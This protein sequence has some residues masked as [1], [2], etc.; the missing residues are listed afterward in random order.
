MSI[1]Y[2]LSVNKLTTPPSYAPRVRPRATTGL[3]ALAQRI[4]DA[5]T[6][7]PA[8]VQ[9]TLVAFTELIESE[10]IAGNWVQL[11]GIGIITT[12]LTGR[13][14]GPTDPLPEDSK[15][16][17]GFRADNRLRKNL[18]ANAQFTRID[19]SDQAPL[20][21]A[22]SVKVGIILPDIRTNDVLELLG[23]RLSV[24]ESKPDEG[25][26]LVP[27]T[28]PALRATNYL[29]NGDKKLLFAVPGG[30]TDN[31]EYTLQVRN[32]RQNSVALRTTSWP[33]LLAGAV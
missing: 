11:D 18:R 13:L 29:S 7:A 3:E 9:A 25:A 5:S 26:F 12:S 30:I 24:D 33:T 4:A 2:E 10:L 19:P 27:A 17:I 23:D 1:E 15:V 14:A 31:T 28:G 6:L 22:L 8:D 32:R 20:L 16:E 21:L